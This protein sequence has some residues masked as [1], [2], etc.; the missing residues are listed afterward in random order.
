MKRIEWQRDEAEKERVKEIIRKM[1]EECEIALKKQWNEAEEL[2]KRTIEEL[3]E[4]IR[5]EA[6][7]E[8]EKRLQKAIKEASVK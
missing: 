7:E 4:K 8:M 1:N 6:E 2:R 3:R 5:K